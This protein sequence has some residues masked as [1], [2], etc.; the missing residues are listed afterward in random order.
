M[1]G[2]IK[3]RLGEL[4]RT[5]MYRLLQLLYSTLSCIQEVN[6]HDKQRSVEFFNILKNRSILS[7]LINTVL[8]YKMSHLGSMHQLRINS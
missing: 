8:V 4:L 6:E 2:H 5:Q 1:N 7:A 3:Q